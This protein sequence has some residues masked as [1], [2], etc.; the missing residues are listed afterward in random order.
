M[1]KKLLFLLTLVF[2]FACEEEKKQNT[3]ILSYIPPKTALILKTDNLT[4][5]SEQ[6]NQ[7]SLIASNR[8][9]PLV[10]FFSDEFTN[11]DFVKISD[12]SLLFMNLIGEKDIALSL[13]SKKIPE[14]KNLDSIQNK[15]V[16]SYTYEDIKIEKYSLENTSFHYANLED[17][18]VISTSNLIVENV[19]RLHQEPIP[20]DQGLEKIYNSS[21]GKSTLIFNNNLAVDVLKIHKNNNS[22]LLHHTDWSAL[23][24]EVTKDKISL[25]GV[26]QTLSTK[27]KIIDIFSDIRPQESKIAHLVPLNATGFYSFTYN[28]L[29]RLKENIKKYRQQKTIET[30]TNEILETINEVGIIYSAQTPI[31]ALR[32]I[33]S[34]LTE[35]TLL[36]QQ[37]LA[38]NFRDINIYDFENGNAFAEFLHPLVKQKSFAFY[39]Q[40]DN[41]FVFAKDLNAIEN[42][43]A[44][45]QNRTTLINQP[46]YQSTLSNLSDQ[47]SILMMALS[48][49]FIKNIQKDFDEEIAKSLEKF[50][51]SDYELAAIQMIKDKNFA[52][53]HAVIQK[54]TEKISEGVA[55]TQSF[56]TNHAIANGPFLFTNWRNKT[57]QI[58]VQ[59]ENNVLIAFDHAGKVNWEKKL[60]SEVI[61]TPQEIDMYN[62]GRKQLAFTTRDKFYIIEKDGNDVKPFPI[63]FKE[64]ITQPLAVFD[65]DNN[66]KYRF[67]VTQNNEIT[68]WDKD[69]KQVKGFT[70]NKAKSEVT[71]TPKHIR[72]GK[73]DYILIQEKNGKLNIL[74]RVGKS[75]VSVNDNIETSTN[76]WFLYDNK[77]T[78]INQAGKLVAVDENGKVTTSRHE[79]AENS[80]MTSTNKTLV[81]LSENKLTIK[82]KTIELDFGLYTTPQIFYIKD[83]IY[84]A[85]TDLQASKVYVYDSDA[86]LFSGFPVYGNSVITLDNIDNKGSLEL[87][88]K[89]E[90]NSILMY[91]L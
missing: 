18:T 33:E 22:N 5:F 4:K 12:E 49:N 85:V 39:A 71:K 50:R 9:F 75:R 40:L 11:Q 31:L 7:N 21:T 24:I 59:D 37:N 32:S 45:Y 66:H 76:D 3:A 34:S 27:P 79:Y 64:N 35:N 38:K 8:E 10:E 84:V 61:G 25:D 13:I 51:V 6:V 63:N 52:H 89:G 46:Y 67:I 55:Q 87:V 60:E 72:I 68:M 28:D 69:G 53:V 62:N 1:T 73:K 88:V 26:T 23:D 29:A 44:N 48:A 80:Q 16:E 14:I 17:L 58:L 20:V 82:D 65:Y 30:Q 78:T 15:M 42:I 86:E 91:Q 90:D 83:K 57:Q 43:I 74:S 36:S 81:T 70:F 19:I 56:K 2:I 77:F 47:S 54:N 41:F